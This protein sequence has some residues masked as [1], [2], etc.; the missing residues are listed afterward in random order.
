M[1]YNKLNA[2]FL[3]QNVDSFIYF[4]LKRCYNS[5]NPKTTSYIG[6]KHS[7]SVFATKGRKQYLFDKKLTMQTFKTTKT[8]IY[9]YKTFKTLLFLLQNVDG[10]ICFEL[11][12]CNDN[13]ISTK[14][15]KVLFYVLKTQTF[16]KI[17]LNRALNDKWSFKNVIQR[18]RFNFQQGI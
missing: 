8:S 9:C 4:E 13:Y 11:K 16:N 5:N 7:S 15:L 12:H 10:I 14:R 6:T 2:Q 3:L 18:T 17:N 1:I